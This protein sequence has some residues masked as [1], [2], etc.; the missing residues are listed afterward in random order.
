MIEPYY[1]DDS[2]TLYL[3]DCREILPQLGRFDLML[4]DPPYGIGVDKTMHRKSGRKYKNS[5]A[6]KGIYEYTDWD[7]NTPEQAFL[8]ACCDLAE[9]SI[10]WG[11]NYFNFGPSS[12]WLVWDKEN[13]T[14]NFADA[15]LAWTN[16]KKSVRIK[17]HMWNGMLR[18]GN[19][20]RNHPAQKPLE[21][22]AWCINLV[23]DGVTSKGFCAG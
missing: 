16:L 14:N 18:K 17:K 22:M 13:G 11:G 5:K 15:E 3:G 8:E 10:V 6:P 4:T 1:Q 12:C 2:V 9:S 21:V 19:E 23:G 20:T 7:A